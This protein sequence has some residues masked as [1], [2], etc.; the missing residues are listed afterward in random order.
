MVHRGVSD[1]GRD[2]NAI[3]GGPPCW[4]L[5]ATIPYGD[6][7]TLGVGVEAP[8]PSLSTG[9]YIAF[10][11]TFHGG[12]GAKDVPSQ[13]VG[14]AIQIECAPN[15]ADPPRSRPAIRMDGRRASERTP[16]RS[17]GGR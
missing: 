8:C 6:T 9:A 5:L 2:R 1:P 16:V 4:S 17:R 7:A 3:C 10:G 13:R 14:R 15:I 12:G 11:L